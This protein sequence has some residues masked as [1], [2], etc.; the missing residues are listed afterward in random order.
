MGCLNK[1]A[2]IPNPVFS[3]RR[4]PKNVLIQSLG[5][6]F[7]SFW[8]P[9]E[10]ARKMKSVVE[11]CILGYNRCSQKIENLAKCR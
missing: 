8:T 9:I 6:V 7:T 11:Q 1:K 3:N 2:N 5:I 4:I 10:S